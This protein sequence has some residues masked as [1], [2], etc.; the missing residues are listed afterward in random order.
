[1]A[2]T[3]QLPWHCNCYMSIG[4]KEMSIRLLDEFEQK[5]QFD[6]QM[7]I[8][9]IDEQKYPLTFKCPFVHWAS[10][11]VHWTFKCQETEKL[12]YMQTLDIRSY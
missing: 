4:Y 11:N 5:C 2:N 12:L 10:R 8:G 7:S 3:L 1:M 6:I 9:P